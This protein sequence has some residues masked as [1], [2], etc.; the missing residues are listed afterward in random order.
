MSNKAF[1]ELLTILDL[2][3][4]ETGAFRGVSPKVGWQRIFGGLV[5]SQALVAASRT[6]EHRLPHSLHCYFLLP[7]D[8]SAPIVYEVER[9]RDGGSFSTRRCVALQ[10]GRTIFVMSA[11]F[12]T[13][14]PGLEHAR[15][16]PEA[17]QPESLPGIEAIR[18]A[19]GPRLP[20]GVRRYFETERPIELRPVDMTRF[21]PEG[22]GKPRAA[23]QKIWMRAAGRL[24]DDPAIHRAVLAYLSDMT[25]LDTSLIVHG[26][27][28]FDGSLQVAS[29]DHALWFHRPFRADEWMLYDQES[30]NAS[31]GRG[32]CRGSLYSQDGRLIA[33]VMQEGLIRQKAP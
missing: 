10:H 28:V 8:P 25:L 32:L 17:P 31:G 4:I 11:S 33:T 21:T 7:G 24:P 26:R 23:A 22:A 18:A 5:I 9:V 2:E 12:Q 14:E 16:M 6:V 20:E 1:T 15:A 13:D 27:S 30:P 29:L 19:L 3:Q